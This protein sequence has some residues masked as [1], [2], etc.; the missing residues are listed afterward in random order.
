MNREKFHQFEG[1]LLVLDEEHRRVYRLPAEM[2]PEAEAVLSE[3]ATSTS[4]RRFLQALAAGSIAG[5]IIIALPSAAAAS[6]LG[7]GGSSGGGNGS[8]DTATPAGDTEPGGTTDPD[9]EV[10]RVAAGDGTVELEWSDNSV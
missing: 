2:V 1:E 3:P 7:D 4:R 5:V 9:L 6:S 8:D 10:T